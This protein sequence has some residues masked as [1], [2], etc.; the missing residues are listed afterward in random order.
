[1]AG[2]FKE[3]AGF[4]G[5]QMPEQL[6]G[7]VIRLCSHKEETVL[8]P[9]AGSATTLVVARKLERNYLGFEL[10][11]EYV[12][13][14]RERLSQARR[15]DPLDGSP[16]PLISAPATP[17][18]KSRR[19]A[20]DASAASAPAADGAVGPAGDD[21]SASAAVDSLLEKGLREA[22]R[23]VA[24]GYSPDRVV[25]DPALN[26]QFADQC[27]VL[28][29]PGD[30]RTW[31][32]RLLN[33]RKAGKLVSVRTAKRT[34]ISW[35]QCDEYLLASE[36]ALAC[37]LRDGGESVD[38][39]LCD[40][41]L[42]EA[43]DQI[44]RRFAPGFTPLEYRWAALK[45]RKEAKVARARS[46]VL[47]KRNNPAGLNRPVAVTEVPWDAVPDAP[48][49][50]LVQGNRDASLADL[51]AGQTLNL[52]DR[53]RR[54]FADATVLAAW[55][56]RSG[57]CDLQIRTSAIDGG[58]SDLLAY[59]SLLIQLHQPLLNFKELGQDVEAES[60]AGNDRPDAR[61][62]TRAKSRR[63]REKVQTALPF[64]AIPTGQAVRALRSSRSS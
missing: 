51:Y 58:T 23:R 54:Q 63:R 27:R 17:R 42:A 36:I 60:L 9:F 5:C 12:R 59:E 14:G 33:F 40:P 6:L 49:V 37:M 55:H 30:R 53:L 48:G 21:F 4:H 57:A 56:E 46:Q 13:R 16:E 26:Q 11:E 15:G 44:A 29:L 34:E 31:N 39:V 22:F 28:G 43:F 2:T 19:R 61:A 3:R 38:E 52:R 18:G 64:D 8:D 1:V 7:R 10:S 20:K 41:K 50:Y 25:A 24:D 62:A 32:R 45:L 35:Q 47:Q